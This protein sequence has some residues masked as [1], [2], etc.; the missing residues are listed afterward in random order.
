MYNIYIQLTDYTI[1]NAI[2]DDVN[3]VKS[4]TQV[5]I[6]NLKSI[7]NDYNNSK[8]LN[9]YSTISNKEISNSIDGYTYKLTPLNSLYQDYTLIGNFKKWINNKKV[10]LFTGGEE[11]GKIKR[12]GKVFVKC[13]IK[14][15]IISVRE[16]QKCFYEIIFNTPCECT[17]KYMK[18]L[19]E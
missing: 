11:C 10:M 16:V 7:I 4:N 18:S 19:L 1:I 14:D 3:I 5:A 8:K 6:D 17:D 9:I 12:K 13:G 2:I 15:E